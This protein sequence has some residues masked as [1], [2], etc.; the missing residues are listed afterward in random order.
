MCGFFPNPEAYAVEV[1]RADIRLSEFI[2]PDTDTIVAQW[3][4]YA[5]TQLSA[6]RT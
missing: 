4:E 6:S 2:L 5:R 1:S 3:D